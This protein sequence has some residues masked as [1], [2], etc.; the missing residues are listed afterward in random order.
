M[1]AR[2]KQTSLKQTDASL[3]RELGTVSPSSAGGG[4]ARWAGA[5]DGR[6]SLRHKISEEKVLEEKSSPASEPRGV[7]RSVQPMRSAIKCS[8]ASRS[9]LHG[10]PRGPRGDV[11]RGE[12]RPRSVP[13]APRL[14]GTPV[15]GG[16]GEGQGGEVG[17]GGMRQGQRHQGAAPGSHMQITCN[18]WA[19]TRL[20]PPRG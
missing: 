15:Y 6:R 14:R 5:G 16:Q 11:G 7:C 3:G 9:P 13:G 10:C 2:A 12:P 17:A 1:R 19:R 20:S 4:S 18:L 8:K